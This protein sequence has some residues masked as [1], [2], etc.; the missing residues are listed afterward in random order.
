MSMTINNPLG[1]ALTVQ[2]V[3]VTWNHDKGRQGNKT[4]SLTNAT[5][6]TSFWSGNINAPSYTITPASLTVP[7]GASTIIFT[8][9]NTYKNLDGTERIFINLSTAGCSLYPIDSNVISNP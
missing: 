1:V 8:F 3:T 2:D 4:L 6:G 9:D 7:N 5:L